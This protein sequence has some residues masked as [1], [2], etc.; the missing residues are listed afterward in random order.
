M[1]SASWYEFKINGN[2]VGEIGIEAA[3]AGYFGVPVLAVTGDEATSREAMATLGDGVEC[4][5][6]KW[7]LGRNRAK[8]L[9]L[10]A[11]HARI[12]EALTKAV[13]N[14]GQLQPYRPELPATLE[15]TFFRPDFADSYYKRTDVERVD[16]RTIRKVVSS[17]NQINFY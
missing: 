4:A 9:S 6:V 3:Y 11:A 5:V 2:V 16:G 8:C 17:M 10:E 1:S 14:I 7:G 15:L 12:R 13:G